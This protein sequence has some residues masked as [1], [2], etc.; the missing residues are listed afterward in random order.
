MTLSL[1]TTR[2]IPEECAWV[3]TA[4]DDADGVEATYQFAAVLTDDGWRIDGLDAIAVEG[5][6]KSEEEL[7]CWWRDHHGATELALVRADAWIEDF[8]L[9]TGRARVYP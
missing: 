7:R 9:M 2:F 6:L 8:E 5:A 4:V 3:V 1:L